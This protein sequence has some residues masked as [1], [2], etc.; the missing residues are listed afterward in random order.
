MCEE[1]Y[2]KRALELAQK[3]FEQDEVPIGAVIVNA[4]T[5]EI[6]SETHNLSEHTDCCTAHAEI[7]AINEACRKLGT[8]RLWDLDLYVTL[9]PCTMCAS[10]ISFARIKT[11]YFG[12]SDMKGGAVENG[13]RFYDSPTCHH[14]PNIQGGIMAKE[15]SFLLKSFFKNKR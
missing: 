14:K 5:G 13:V 6:I 8:N 7:L 2:M 9:E 4:Q 11:L 3:A 12:A 1:I 15:A 10:A